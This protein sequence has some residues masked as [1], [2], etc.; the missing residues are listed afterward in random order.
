MNEPNKENGSGGSVTVGCGK[1]AIKQNTMLNASSM[2]TGDNIVKTEQ[3]DS[4]ELAQ[5]MNRRLKP[6]V[7][8]LA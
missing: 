8:G 4:R 2:P 6:W 3:P 1:E 7:I 5:T